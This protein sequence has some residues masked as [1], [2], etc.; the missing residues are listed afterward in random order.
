MNQDLIFKLA[1]KS[2]GEC[3]VPAIFAGEQLD[4]IATHDTN[5]YKNPNNK[6]LNTCCGSGTYIIETYK[7]LMSGLETIIPDQE[8]RKRHI[9]QNML[10][11]ID[12]KYTFIAHTINQL[13]PERKYINPSNFVHGDALTYKW[14]TKFD[15]IMYSAPFSQTSASGNTVWENHYDTYYS[16]LNNNGYMLTNLPPRWRSPVVD[17]NFSAGKKNKRFFNSLKNKQFILIRMVNN[18]SDV[19]HTRSDMIVFKNC[20]RTKDCKIIDIK[21]TVDYINLTEFDWIP[22]YMIKEIQ[23]ILTSDKNQRINISLTYECER[24]L[25]HVNK[26][27][28]SNANHKYPCVNSITKDG[29]FK[30]YYSTKNDLPIMNTRKVILSHSGNCYAYNDYNKEYGVTQHMY[31]IKI[32][33]NEEANK[34]CKFVKSSY[35]NKLSDACKWSL[36]CA[37][38]VDALSFFN[39]NIYEKY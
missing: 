11:A 23:S 14:N 7:R 2:K 39:K 37:G 3:P 25:K 12:I 35:F 15:V 9:L 16:I 5:F 4:S 8:I 27:T 38:I 17:H 31:Y 32:D 28:E 34:I 33:S 1:R 24:R 21:G 19:K 6:F 13:D 22:N 29:S 18:N 26:V 20:K 36:Q 30:F 10:Y